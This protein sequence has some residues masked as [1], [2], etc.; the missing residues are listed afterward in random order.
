[1]FEVKSFLGSIIVLTVI[2]E[3]WIWSLFEKLILIKFYQICGFKKIVFLKIKKCFFN[4]NSAYCVAE[5][6]RQTGKVGP[7]ALSEGSVKLGSGIT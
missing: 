4:P 1:M 3:S 5:T 7:K 2:V 6:G